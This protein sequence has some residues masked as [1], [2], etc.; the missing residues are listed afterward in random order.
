M[1][2][3]HYK[4]FLLVKPIFPSLHGFRLAPLGGAGAGLDLASAARSVISDW[5]TG[6]KHGR[7][8]RTKREILGH[9][10]WLIMIYHYLD[11]FRF[12]MIYHDW[13]WYSMLRN[14][15]ENFDCK[16]TWEA[17]GLSRLNVG[18]F[19]RQMSQHCAN[20]K[21]ATLMLLAKSPMLVTRSPRCLGL[22][23]TSCWK[24]W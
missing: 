3:P 11:L 22:I 23:L 12:I 18:D 20:R 13:S 2:K 4:C 1:D 14:W 9:L 10:S 7:F 21:A 17:S 6:P 24:I 16:K 5:T 19:T 8:H 15:F